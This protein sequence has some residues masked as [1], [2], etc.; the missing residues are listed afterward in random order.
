MIQVIHDCNMVL[1]IS[2]DN[3]SLVLFNNLNISETISKLA[4]LYPLELILWCHTDLISFVN[5]EQ[6][7]SICNS[8]SEMI[9]FTNSD[10][11]YLSKNIGFVE[12]SVFINFSKKVKIATWQM[13]SAIGIAHSA[14][15]LAVKT[16]IKPVKDFDYFLNSVAKI[17]MPLGV[18]CYSNPNLLKGS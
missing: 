18:F 10:K 9:S 15:F 5:Y 11:N 8:N 14:V 3:K 7:S 17:V 12:Q 1:K 16:T 13:S 6:L 2:Q 4:E